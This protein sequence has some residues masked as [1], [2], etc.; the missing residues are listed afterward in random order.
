MEIVQ[1]EQLFLKPD[2]L[3]T[4]KPHYKSEKLPQYTTFKPNIWR[5]F[6]TFILYLYTC[7]GKNG[8][9]WKEERVEEPHNQI[10][11]LVVLLSLSSSILWVW[12]I[13]NIKRTAYMHVICIHMYYNLRANP[14]SWR[15]SKE[16]NNEEK[17]LTLKIY[18]Q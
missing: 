7:E 11:N 5:D 13:L 6:A 2:R 4:L 18:C 3:A 16:R 1:G 14:W 8:E 9:I 17:C 12:N 10:Q 15:W